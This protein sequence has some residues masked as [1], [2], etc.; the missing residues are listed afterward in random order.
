MKDVVLYKNLLEQISKAPQQPGVYIFKSKKNY[1]YI[2]KAKNLK[3]RLKGHLQATKL[4]P[5]ER[6]IFEESSQLEWIITSSD[7]EAFVLENE[8]IKQYKPKYNVRLK[9]GS[10]YPMLVITNDEYPTV[11]ISRKF[12]EIDGEYF[13]PFIPAKT[14]RAMKELIHK[15]FKLR[16]CDPMPKRDLVCFDYH[17]GLCSAPCANKI[18]KKD[19]Q[20][21]A[22]SAKAF[23]SGNAKKIIYQLYDKIEEYT[24]KLMFEKA[25]IVRDQIIALE[26]LIKKQEVVGL[27]IEEADVFYITQTSIYLIIVRGF[28]ILGKDEIK[29]DGTLNENDISLVIMNYYQ[30]GNYIPK[31]I[32]LNREIPETLNLQKWLSKFKDIKIE[33]G[34]IKEIENFIKRNIS[35]I[36]LSTIS[37]E[38]K[39][40]FGFD[41]PSKIEGFDISTLQG[42]FTVGSCVVWENGKM[43]KKEYRRFKVKTV[44]GVDDYASMRE[45]LYRRLKKYL[46]IDN[47][48]ELILID[49]GKGQLKQG[50]IVKDAL[51]IKNL[52][53]FSLAKKEEIIYTDDNKEVNLYNYQPLL[54]LFT[55]I[56]DEAHR[57]AVLYN[58]KLREKEGLKSVLD[59]IKGIGKKRKEI[60]YRT[61]KTI[62]NISKASEEE[63]I[64]LGIPRKVAQEIKHYLS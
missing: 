3:N 52:R 4:D 37:K 36:D 57:F 41:L 47:P 2:G 32:L 44:K 60:L 26:N 62:D 20:F 55:T 59:N 29:I 64:K 13:G 45:V 23:L 11:K 15:I 10:S 49:G 46:E 28:R 51:G 22:K 42:D 63:L 25:S 53:I 39:S 31:Q 34:L 38:F 50:L 43:N 40:V 6:K 24:Q 1:I 19:Y 21:D 54:K 56:R 27:P 18:S 35:D 48:P 61:Y 58:R 16:T 5:K 30:K 33:I 8:L 17:L 9:S 7:Y 12:G 14:A